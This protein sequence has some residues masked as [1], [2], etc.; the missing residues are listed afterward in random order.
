M[1][2]VCRGTMTGGGTP[3]EGP[4]TFSNLTASGITSGWTCCIS[5]LFEDDDE[6]PVSSDVKT[7]TFLS[8]NN[9]FKV[10]EYI[11]QER[12]DKYFI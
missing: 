9:N 1:S 4:Y 2:V 5:G 8:G 11:N 6:N 7:C 10:D 12:E 3:I